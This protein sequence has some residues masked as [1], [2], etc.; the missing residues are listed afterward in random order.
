MY[1][2]TYAHVYESSSIIYDIIIIP[3]NYHMQIKFT[4][5]L[6]MGSNVLNFLFICLVLMITEP[7]GDFY[8][9][10]C[11]YRRQIHQKRCTNYHVGEN[12]YLFH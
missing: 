2:A 1:K 7:Y 12:N 6:Y 4:F 9:Y 5:S 3:E 10:L 11:Y 8:H